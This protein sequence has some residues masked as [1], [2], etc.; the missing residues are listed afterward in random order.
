MNSLWDI[1]IFLGLVP[2][3]SPCIFSRLRKATVNT[4]KP[5]VGLQLLAPRTFQHH[6][7]K[8]TVGP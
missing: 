1:R 3:E 8:K 7:L 5:A 4:D 6:A 2:K